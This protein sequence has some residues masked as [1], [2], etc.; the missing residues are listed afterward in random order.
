M[1]DETTT[2]DSGRLLLGLAGAVGAMIVCASQAAADGQ[3]EV[4]IPRPLPHMQD[5]KTPPNN[6]VKTNSP[7]AARPIPQANA[8]PAPTKAA[9]RRLEAPHTQIDHVYFDEHADGTVWALGTT[10]KA[11]FDA[12]GATYIPFLGSCAPQ[13][14]PV[15]FHLKNITSG[16]APIAF[17]PLTPAMHDGMRVAYDRGGVTELYALSLDSVEQ[18]FTFASVPAGEL[19]LQLDVGT[20][21]DATPAGDG[22]RWSNT[23]G[24]VTYSRAVVVDANGNRTPVVTQQEGGV[25]EIRV[26]ADLVASAAYPI[27]IDPVIGTFTVDASTSDDLNPDIAF[28]ATNNV[29]QVCWER[30]F[31]GSDHDCYSQLQDQA[32]TTIAGSF[33]TIDFT[34]DFWAVPRT[35]NN[36]IAQQFLVAAQVTPFGGGNRVIKGVTRAA[37]GNATSSQFQISDPAITDDQFNV[38]VGGD[39]NPFAP[40]YYCV[41]WQRIFIAGS[42]TD[43][44]ARL[45]LSNATL[46][47]TSTIFVENSS[48][49]LDANPSVSK[50]DGNQPATGQDWTIVFQRE[51]SST[52][53]DIRGAQ[54]HWD[55][56]P[57]GPS[58]NFSYSIDASTSDDT[59]P[60]VSS[61]VDG[62][63]VHRNYMVTYQ[64]FYGP[65][66]DIQGIMGNSTSTISGS[67]DLSV[68]EGAAIFQDQIQSTVDSDGTLF[69][70]TYSEQFMSSA[71]DYDIYIA[72]FSGTTNSIAVVDPH[73]NLAFSSDPEHLPQVVARHSGGV[74]SS[75]YGVVWSDTFGASD[76]DV[77]G[78]QY[79]TTTAVAYCGGG[80]GFLTGCP[81]GNP[82]LTGRGCNNSVN[83]GGGLLTSSGTS[84]LSADTL[85]FTQ[86]GELN[87]SLSIFLQGNHNLPN[88]VTFGDGVRCAGGTLK[89]LYTHNASGGTVQAPVGTDLAVHARSAALGDTITLGSQRFYQVYYRDPNLTFCSFGFNVGN[90]QAVTWLP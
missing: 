58:F 22:L 27:V 40:T 21:L 71:T 44:F 41:A 76:H 59:H 67:F 57:N 51:F 87:T 90:G 10:Y 70:V 77:Y 37:G 26:P 42:D 13:N 49:T 14:Y 39:P 78:N 79:C 82:G 47:G 16:G 11:S 18:E 12:T 33:A 7:P 86:S 74:A 23:L 38:T 4:K 72:T 34:S 56:T 63:G 88:G 83:T 45:V 1:K 9:T 32:G 89:R 50:S 55:G 6:P 28:D 64:R 66:N 17:D 3:G 53:H 25:I 62:T 20:T 2:A 73:V 52:D 24:A 8:A 19:V 61:V 75:C 48:S 60:A 30:V 29:Y 46:L 31:S 81:C 54:I 84:S 68:L 85:H 15:S 36:L 5:I 80:T 69:G 65:D 43:I 35:A